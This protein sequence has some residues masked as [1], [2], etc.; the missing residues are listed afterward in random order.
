M[1]ALRSVLRWLSQ[2]PVRNPSATIVRTCSS[3]LNE[4]SAG[5]CVPISCNNIYAI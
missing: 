3:L 1:L 4:L 2:S 5:I